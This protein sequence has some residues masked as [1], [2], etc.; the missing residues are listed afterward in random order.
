MIDPKDLD[1][2]LALQ[3]TVA[4]AGEK[5]ED[6]QRLNWWN[7]DLTDERAGGDLF[8]RL[9]PKTAKWAGLELVREAALRVDSAARSKLANPDGARTLFHFGFELDEAISDR[10]EHHK[11][12][13][14]APK[15]V[16]GDTLGVTETW[17]KKAFAGFLKE[18]GKATIEDTPLGRLLKKLDPSPAAAARSLAAAL[19]P[20]GDRYPL[21]H[22]MVAVS[23]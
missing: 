7:T 10:L 1:T 14:K 15:D 19:L 8:A 9:L 22:A 16:F 2:I 13:G 12:H 3:L 4:W 17:D 5:A 18:Q 11:R 21:P 20:L 23:A 6:P